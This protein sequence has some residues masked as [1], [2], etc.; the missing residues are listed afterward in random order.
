MLA[1]NSH[2]NSYLLRTNPGRFNGMK[3]LSVIVRAAFATLAVGIFGIGG[4]AGDAG[5]V[6]FV[7]PSYNLLL[8]SLIFPDFI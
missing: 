8:C 1:K 5:D 6:N 4:C 3:A 7:Q 2:Q